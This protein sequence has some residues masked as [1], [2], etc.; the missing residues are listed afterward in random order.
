MWWCYSGDR[1]EE[2][3]DSLRLCQRQDAGGGALPVI[4]LPGCECQ[5]DIL[6]TPA[7]L[8]TAASS[9]EPAVV[10]CCVNTAVWVMSP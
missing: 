5:A 1:L 4:G 10:S 6:I 2:V 7:C 8:H 9:S 3:G